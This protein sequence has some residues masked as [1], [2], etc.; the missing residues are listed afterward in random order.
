MK[1]SAGYQ[2]DTAWIDALIA[3]RDALCDV[4]FAFGAMPSGRMA[5]ADEEN[6]GSL[7]FQFVFLHGHHGQC[8]SNHIIPDRRIFCIRG[9]ACEHADAR[10]ASRRKRV[11]ACLQA[12]CRLYQLSKNDASPPSEKKPFYIIPDP[13]YLIVLGLDGFTVASGVH[14]KAYNPAIVSVPLKLD[15]TIHVGIIYRAGI[16]LSAAGV[17]F[18]DAIRACVAGK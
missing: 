4:Y 8:V 9:K 14:A 6:K 1:F 11:S 5:V 17:A 3:R 13:F 16:P 7:L 18:V 2:A 12:V 15:E 10:G